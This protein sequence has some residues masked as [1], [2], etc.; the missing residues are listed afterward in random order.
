MSTPIQSTSSGFKY[1]STKS[2]SIK[3]VEDALPK[4]PHKRKEVV[5]ALV[6]K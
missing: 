4:S 6:K 2:R 5:S 3:K 1:R